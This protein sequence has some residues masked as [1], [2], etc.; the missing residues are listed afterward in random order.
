MCSFVHHAKS[1]S[2]SNG[3]EN[4]KNVRNKSFMFLE[5]NKIMVKK[6]PFK[7]H[8]NMGKVFG[9]K[10]PRKNPPSLQFFKTFGFVKDINKKNKQIQLKEC[11]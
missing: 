3:I 11:F 4:S 1:D 5:N 7:K 2:K 9:K 6:K 10:N 8:I